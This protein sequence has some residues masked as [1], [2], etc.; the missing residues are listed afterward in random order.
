VATCSL[1]LP[2]VQAQTGTCSTHNGACVTCYTLGGAGCTWCPELIATG[3]ACISLG[4]PCAY[5]VSQAQCGTQCTASTCPPDSTCSN[6]ANNQPVCTCNAGFRSVDPDPSDSV[7]GV[8]CVPVQGDGGQVG[9]ACHDL[10]DPRDP[11]A[12]TPSFDAAASCNRLTRNGVDCTTTLELYRTAARTQCPSTCY[13][14]CEASRHTTGSSTTH[15][16]CGCASAANAAC[17]DFTTIDA[18]CPVHALGR[19]VPATCDDPHSTSDDKCAHVYTAWYHRCFAQLSS[20]TTSG[21]QAVIAQYGSELTSFNT[22]CQSRMS[23]TCATHPCLNGGTCVSTSHSGHRRS[24]QSTGS[25]HTCHCVAG[26]EG[27]HCDVVERASSALWRRAGCT[28]SL[29]SLATLQCTTTTCRTILRADMATYWASE[30]DGGVS[31][32]DAWATRMDEEHVR[33]CQSQAQCR[34]NPNWCT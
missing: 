18:N 4:S 22:L 31:D 1:L 2:V 9:A 5:T 13:P 27:V 26:Y 10:G 28:T 12:G 6:G 19:I 7:P 20:D 11:G 23:D 14:I 8:M 32:A 30:P 24:L 29:D 33:G 3:G 21:M 16:V 17:D 25:D 34:S 15:D